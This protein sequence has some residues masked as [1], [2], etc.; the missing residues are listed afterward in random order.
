MRPIKLTM[1]AFGPY[2]DLVEVDFTKF[3]EKG[4]FLITGDTGAGKTTIFDGI[5]FALFGESSGSNRETNSFRS[6]FAQETTETFVTLEFKANNKEYKVT[7]NPSYE[8]PKK[9][10]DGT[11]MRP[12]DATLECNGEIIE[13]KGTNVSERIKSILGIDGNQFK[14]IAMLAQGE[15]LSVLLAPSKER[16]DIFRKIFSTERLMMITNRLNEKQ[17]QE[18]NKLE[19]LKT[20]F[21][22]HTKMIKNIEGISVE[23]KDITPEIIDEIIRTLEEELKE[24]EVIHK[25]KSKK[26]E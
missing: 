10:G 25:D 16:G 12:A 14:K 23:E 26:L 8:V 9:R 21:S 15:F 5:S 3:G 11:T 24:K 20:E 13:S 7:R 18:K 19:T 2:K 1:S 17:K 22:T 4:I 6:K